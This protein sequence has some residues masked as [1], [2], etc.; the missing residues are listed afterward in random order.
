[1]KKTGEYGEYFPAQSSIFGYNETVAQEYYPLTKEVAL[2]QG[3]N[4]QDNLPFTRGLETLK[5][6]NIP[7]NIKEMSETILKEVLACQEC[8]KNYKIIN[9]ELEFYRHKYLPIPRHCPECRH[10]NRL[11]LRNPRKLWERKCDQCGR[12]VKTTYAPDRPEK[13]FCEECYQKEIY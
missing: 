8:G 5:F 3:F 4:W 6:S 13:I 9:Q 12:E 11:K 10:L 2:K 1:M 7:D